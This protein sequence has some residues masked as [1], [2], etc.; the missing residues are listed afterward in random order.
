MSGN[1]DMGHP[2]LGARLGRAA[3]G[4]RGWV[5]SSL[6]FLLRLFASPVS[7]F[8]SLP[9]ESAMLMVPRE[10]LTT[11][12]SAAGL[13]S[14]KLPGRLSTGLSFSVIVSLRMRLDAEDEEG[15]DEAR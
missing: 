1:P 8:S 6:V 7:F 13:A 3:A 2:D 5:Q 14:F 4:M 11:P 15:V 9:V 12:S 10:S